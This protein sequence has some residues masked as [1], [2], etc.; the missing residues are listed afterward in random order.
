MAITAESVVIEVVSRLDKAQ[1]DLKG[2]DRSFSET[3]S[4]GGAAMSRLETTVN[5]AGATIDQN[6]RRIAA[7]NRNIGRQYSD[8]AAQLAGGQSPFLIAAQQAPQ[9]ADALADTGGRAAKIASFFAGPWG[10]AILGAGSILGTTLIPKLLEAGDAADTMSDSQA[11][12]ARFVDLATGSINRQITAVERLAAAQ[13]RQST[14]E[15]TTTN[16]LNSRGGAIGA[17]RQAAGVRDPIFTAGG[18]TTAPASNDPVKVRLRQLVGEVSAGKRSINDFALAVRAAVGDRPEYRALV[19]TVTAQ[20]AAAADAARNVNRLKAEQALLNGTATDQQKALLGVG[21]ATTRLIEN[22]VALATATT[23]TERARARLALVE[24]QGRN[25]QAGDAKGLETYRRNLTQ[26]QQA[27]NAAEAS[28]RAA[29]AAKREGAVATRDAAKA[30]RQRLQ[31]L[32]DA[33][34]NERDLIGLNSDLIASKGD[35]TSDTRLQDEFQRQRIRLDRDGQASRLSEQRQLGDLSQAEYDERLKL[36]DAI[37]DNRLRLVNRNEAIRTADE[38]LAAAQQRIGN[39][40]ELL[41]AQ[42]GFARTAADRAKVQTELLDLAI[43]ERRLTAQ[44]V[45]DLATRGQASPEEAARAQE[46]LNFLP[47]ARLAGKRAIDAQNMSPGAAYL[48]SLPGTADEINEAVEAIEVSGLQRL[49]SELADAIL[50]AKSLGDVFGS[51]AEQIISDLLRIAIQQAI[52]KP[53]AERLFDGA[54]AA[55]GAG[56][57]TGAASI[58]GLFGK[59]FGRVSGGYVG[60]GQTVRVNEG[61][62]GVELLR[63][64]SQGGTVIPLGQANSIA[65]PSRPQVTVL[66]PQQFDLRGVF[67][68]ETTLR[69]LEDRNRQYADAVG[70]SVATGVRRGLPAALARYDRLGTTG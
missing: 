41:T 29:T 65:R 14:I 68:N 34:R 38:E 69:Q 60:P 1:R 66:A 49:N 62:G 27:V 50:G 6:A 23:A 17:V 46:V 2:L 51:V 28:E 59:L 5:R 63:M 10:A 35:L 61:R 33:A 56:G 7:A 44:R 32:R 22:Q 70:Q 67:L 64:G 13:A 47:A 53:L 8:I 16:Y 15:A 24:E 40:R 57:A 37:T 39:D 25:V 58:V 19:R 9:L 11:D 26:A 4:S 18:V 12:L 54:T 31:Q 20:S 3:A 42:E 21:R 45:L 52:I 43:E 48:S 36:I 55:A 30:E